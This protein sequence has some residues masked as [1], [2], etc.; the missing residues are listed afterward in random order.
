MA[1]YISVDEQS[2]TITVE[3]EDV[4]S[5]TFTNGSNHGGHITTWYDLQRT[6]KLVER[7]RLYNNPISAGNIQEYHTLRPIPQQEIDRA[8]NTMTQ[9]PGY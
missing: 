3:S 7:V 4:F 9:N 6:G 2:T 1:S 5:I 8:T